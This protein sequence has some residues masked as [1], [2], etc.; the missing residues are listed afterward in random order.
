MVSALP[1]LPASYATALRLID[2]AHAEDPRMTAT[3]TAGAGAS[4]AA[5][6]HQQEQEEGSKEAE[7][8]RERVRVGVPFELDYARKMTAWLAR[9][10][11]GAAP[12]LQLACRA[13]H[14]RRW[15]TPRSAYPATRAGYLTW[16]AKQK[17]QAAERVRALLL[18]PAPDGPQLPEDEAAR[19]AALVRKEGLGAGDEEAQALEDTACLVFLDDQLADFDARMRASAGDEGG[20]DKL[21][22]ILRKTW[23]KMGPRGRELALGVD[24]GAR[25]GELVRHALEG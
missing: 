3:T 22:A 25:A 10:S 20:E 14:F 2:A 8:E 12:A 21:I 16:R 15:E 11:P 24:Y 1:P 17:T 7:V 6:K 18:A 23:G 19:V 4:S 5:G 9:R 13:Q